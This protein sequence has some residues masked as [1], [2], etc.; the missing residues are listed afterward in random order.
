M[1][2]PMMSRIALL[3]GIL[4]ALCPTHGIA[5]DD[6]TDGHFTLFN[7]CRPVAL[8]VVV[9]GWTEQAHGMGLTEERLRVIAE[10]RLRSARLYTARAHSVLF[11]EVS[12]V[13]H[14][15]T[16]EAAFIKRLFDPVSNQHGLAKTWWE[17]KT[18]THGGNVTVI[19]Q[20]L[21]EEI[22][23]FILDYLRVNE[24]HCKT[25]N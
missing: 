15:F 1:V 20:S 24:T 21:S 5:Q 4:I 13:N 25:I 17:G 22:D 9:T 3:A 7:R 2:L 14:A 11:I 19:L 18:G 10:S 16:T 12:V 8:S 23:Q 6:R